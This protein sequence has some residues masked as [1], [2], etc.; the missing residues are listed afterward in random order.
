MNKTY[1]ILIVIA[2]LVYET[3]H[4]V[5]LIYSPLP[6][7]DEVTFTSITNSFINHHTFYEEARIIVL[8]QQKLDYGPVY[9]LIQAGVIKMLGFSIF[10]FRLTGLLFGFIDLYLIYGI[11]KHFKF[12][13]NAIVV[14]LVLIGLEPNFNQFLHSGRMDFI[15]LF[16]FLL[17]YLVFVKIG[18]NIKGSSISLS[19]ATGILLALAI[20][21]TP[22]IVFAFAF[23]IFYF[24]YECMTIKSRDWKA[25]FLKYLF[26]FAG[27]IIVYGIWVYYAFGSVGNFIYY[28]AHSAVIK[29][30]TGADA[31]IS[32]RYNLL[33][34]VYA[35]LAFAILL[36]NKMVK[37]NIGIILFTVPVIVSFLM[38]V[39]GGISGRYFALIVPFAAI[40]IVG[41]TVNL[42]NSALLKGITYVIPVLFGLVF[43]FKGTY[44]F[45]TMKQHDPHY[46]EA[47][48]SKYISPNSSIVGDF[49]YYYIARD[50][51]CT[52][53]SIEENGP[54]DNKI[55]YFLDH[56]IN[57]FI[58]NKDNPNKEAYEQV[59]LHNNYQLVTVVEDD[60]SASF[61]HKVIMKLPYKISENYSCYIY[62]YIGG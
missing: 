46:N 5:T 24:A 9:F 49:R 58:I 17:S 38:L 21:T 32:I 45:G 31:R 18:D 22:R 37:N 35:F 19:L 15:T 8:P 7:F 10:S 53:L 2:S 47:V 57:Y 40:L 39:T 36:K 20:L 26:I 61:F 34:Y 55:K 3:Y 25:L 59:L 27:F 56:K 52:F 11:C 30:H 33:I 1:K 44:I 42:Y 51:N 6:W 4:L 54:W 60:N 50:N 62:K 29:E 16:F 43:I 41:V 28:N 12:S 14:T 23:Y 13:I 48:I